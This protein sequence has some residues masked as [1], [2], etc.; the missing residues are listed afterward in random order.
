[1]FLYQLSKYRE[2]FIRKVMQKQ[3][4]RHYAMPGAERMVEDIALDPVSV[5]G[6]ERRPACAV[7]SVPREAARMHFPPETA[8]SGAEFKNPIR[9][10]D[11]AHI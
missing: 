3:T 11:A 9:G 6:P 2:L 8:V 5:L 7:E 10:S 1:M 4:R